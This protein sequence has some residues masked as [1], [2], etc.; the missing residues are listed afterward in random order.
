MAY[1]PKVIFS[2]AY[3]DPICIPSIPDGKI[4][5]GS[6]SPCSG[7]FSVV[8]VIPNLLIVTGLSFPSTQSYSTSRA[9][10]LGTLTLGERGEPF[11]IP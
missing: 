7:C 11:D 2:Y 5:F 9:P 3:T 6:L 10:Y 1:Y 8:C 4:S